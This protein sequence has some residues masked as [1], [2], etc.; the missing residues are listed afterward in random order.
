MLVKVDIPID[1]QNLFAI[2]L[3]GILNPSADLQNVLKR[4]NKKALSH[5]LSSSSSLIPVDYW[6]DENH[7]RKPNTYR[8][9]S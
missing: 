1:Q 9:R 5:A 7:F 4:F 2:E 3:P 6:N 8:K